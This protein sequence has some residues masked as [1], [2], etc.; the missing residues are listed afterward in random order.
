[1][2]AQ[3]AGATGHASLDLPPTVERRRSPV[4]AVPDRVEAPAEVLYRLLWHRPVGES[5][6]RVSGDEGRVRAF[7]GSRLTP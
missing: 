3:P 6:L 5:D 4:A 2:P 1:M 7:L